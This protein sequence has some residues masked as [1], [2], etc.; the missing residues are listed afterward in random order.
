MV[1]TFEVNAASFVSFDLNS[2]PSTVSAQ[3]LV[4]CV[5]ISITFITGAETA[6][7]ESK[8]MS[9]YADIIDVITAC[10]EVDFRHPT[11]KD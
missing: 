4:P 3:V 1:D 10:I 2:D 7:V 6:A 8:R 11:K 9:D 5:S